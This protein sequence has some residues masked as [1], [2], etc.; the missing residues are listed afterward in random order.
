MVFPQAQE[1]KEKVKSR[2]F[3]FK[4][5]LKYTCINLE[6]KSCLEINSV[7]KPDIGSLVL[8]SSLP[9]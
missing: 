8:L 1:S 6:G 3:F 5:I 4:I 9:N 7:L 2:I